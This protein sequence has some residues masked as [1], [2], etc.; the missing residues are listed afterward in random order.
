MSECHD[1]SMGGGQFSEDRQLCAAAACWLLVYLSPGI[2]NC[3]I[4]HQCA[5]CFEIGGKAVAVGAG[6]VSRVL[7][8]AKKRE[9]TTAYTLATIRE[10]FG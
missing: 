8:N 7:V 5:N 9:P 2:V 4:V 6:Q 10:S 3:F 1:V